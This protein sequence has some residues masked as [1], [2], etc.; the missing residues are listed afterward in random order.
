MNTFTF[1]TTLF[2]LDVEVTATGYPAEK[3]TLEYPGCEATVE[4]E[5]VTH[6]GVEIEL[7]GVYT[8]QSHSF[9]TGVYS[10][11]EDEAIDAATKEAKEASDQYISEL[12]NT[13]YG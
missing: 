13:F 1:N 12:R 8:R 10:L 3:M 5:S 2:G 6:K 11:L 4:I 7:D 9:Y